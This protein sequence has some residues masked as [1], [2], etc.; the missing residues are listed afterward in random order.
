ME[1]ESVYSSIELDRAESA[2]VEALI[3]EVKS[4]GPHPD[5][6]SNSK[7]EQRQTS[8]GFTPVEGCPV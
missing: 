4:R 6:G 1:I 7:P 3:A 2:E 8:L 5:L